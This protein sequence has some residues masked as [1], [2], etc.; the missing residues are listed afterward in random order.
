MCRSV[1]VGRREAEN[2]VPH[3]GSEARGL[4]EVLAFHVEHHGGAL[5]GQQVRDHEPHAL[6]PA[7]RR[8][9]QRVGEGF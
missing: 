6:A 2:L 5:V 9:D 8:H 7:C 3:A 1:P 4:A